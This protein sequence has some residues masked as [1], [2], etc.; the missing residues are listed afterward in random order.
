MNLG[1]PLTYV[2]VCTKLHLYA[3]TYKY[4]NVQNDIILQYL[5]ESD[6]RLRYQRE[7][8]TDMYQY[9]LQHNYEFIVLHDIYQESMHHT[10][11]PEYFV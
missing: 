1:S 8:C 4:G 6:I 9:I 10:F 11:S 2:P 5:I 7:L 3:N